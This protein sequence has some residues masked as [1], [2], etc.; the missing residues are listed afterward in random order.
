MGIVGS[1]NSCTSPKKKKVGK[2]P[3]DAKSSG[4]NMLKTGKN[5]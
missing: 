2:V 5:E 4:K 3:V 1:P